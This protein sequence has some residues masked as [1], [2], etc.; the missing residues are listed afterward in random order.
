MTAFKNVRARAWQ[1]EFDLV[2]DELN[3]RRHTRERARR[4]G[5]NRAHGACMSPA[6]A[7]AASCL[8]EQVGAMPPIPMTKHAAHRLKNRGISMAQ[9]LVVADFGFAQRSHGATRYALD[10]KARQ[11]LAEVVSPDA[12]RRTGSLDIVAVFSDEGALVTA[13]HRT[14]RLRRDITRH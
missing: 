9:I 11:L 14:G 2:D 5:M 7:A 13:S 1:H 3:A 6:P 4:V 12:L 10:K 8:P